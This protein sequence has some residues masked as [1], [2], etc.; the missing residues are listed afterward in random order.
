M[1][2]FR[3]NIPA[4]RTPLVTIL[5]I[6][7]NAGCFAYQSMLP[8]AESRAFAYR[9][10]LVPAEFQFV[11]QGP[12]LITVQFREVVPVGP[13]RVQRVAAQQFQ[14]EGTWAGAIVPLFTSMFLHGGLLHLLGNMWYLWLFGDNVEDRLGHG[15]F[16]GLYVLSG[17]GAGATHVWASWDSLVPTIGASG[18]VAGVLGAYVITYPYARILTWVPFFY[19]LWPVIELPAIVFLG[20]WFLI[21]ALSGAE[22]LGVAPEQGGV[23]WWAHIGGFIAGIVLMGLLAPEPKGRRGETWK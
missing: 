14:V 12:Q 2:P 15:R 9:F 3:D 18:A 1:I 22:S 23:A 8:T 16:L 20:I 11:G 4:Q 7:L 5:L 10:G 21:Q 17:L 13:A 6:G 19:F